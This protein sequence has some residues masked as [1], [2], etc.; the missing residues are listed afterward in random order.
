MTT[1][2]Q[3]DDS[4]NFNSNFDDC[5]S[6]NY[7]VVTFDVILNSIQIRVQLIKLVC[8]EKYK[9]SKA[10]RALN[11]NESTAKYIVRTFRKKGKILMKF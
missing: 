2:N 7:D 11:I 4:F 1:L 8:G 9:I 6:Q 10:A 3:K 5:Q